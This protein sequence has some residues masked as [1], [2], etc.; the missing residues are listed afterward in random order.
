MFLNT[1]VEQQAL[2]QFQCECSPDC[3]LHT[4]GSEKNLAYYFSLNIFIHVCDVGEKIKSSYLFGMEF[5]SHLGSIHTAVQ[6]L[7]LTMTLQNLPGDCITYNCFASCY[8]YVI[9]VNHP[10]KGKLEFLTKAGNIMSTL[11]GVMI[12]LSKSKSIQ[13]NQQSFQISLIHTWIN[14]GIWVVIHKG[15]STLFKQTARFRLP[16]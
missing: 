6:S 8:L 4:K 3:C 12:F 13:K 9:Q 10:V 7:T 15:A 5:S 14:V 2:P 1:W 11:G 16:N